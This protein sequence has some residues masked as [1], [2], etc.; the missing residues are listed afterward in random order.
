[1]ANAM[2]QVLTDPVFRAELSEQGKLRAIQFRWRET[3]RQTWEI[4]L[5]AS[6]S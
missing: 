3:A 2:A 1:M 6:G 5:E 4:L